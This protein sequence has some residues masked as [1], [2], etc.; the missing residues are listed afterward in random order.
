[1]TYLDTQ[2]VR[3]GY[4]MHLHTR[5][6]MIVHIPHTYKHTHDYLLLNGKLTTFLLYNISISKYPTG[7]GLFFTQDYFF[8][9][10]MIAA[11][12]KE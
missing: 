4:Y 1:M 2:S 9:I 3:K 7:S 11:Y 6:H 5:K 10:M 12:L 8:T